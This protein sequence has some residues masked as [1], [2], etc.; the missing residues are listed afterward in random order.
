MGWHGTVKE[1]EKVYSPG[2]EKAS[3]WKYHL[4]CEAAFNDTFFFF[5]YFTFLKSICQKTEN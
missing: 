1:E 2:S 4:N 5:S 3:L